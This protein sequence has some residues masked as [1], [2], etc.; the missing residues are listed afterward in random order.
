MVE[1]YNINRDKKICILYGNCQ[2]DGL[3]KFLIYSKFY[4]IYDTY[5]FPNWRMIENE[6]LFPVQLM[7]IADLIIYQ[8]LTEI[9]GCYST[10]INS[11]KSFFKLLKADCI[12]ISFP[13]IHN[14]ALFP[15]F[16]KH[17]CKNIFYG[18]DDSIDINDKLVNIL[19]K[20]KTNKL[21]FNFEKRW[22]S[23]IE[24]SRKREEMCDIKIIDFIIS[25][26]SKYKLFLTQDHPTSIV[27][28]EVA[29]QICVK[30]GLEYN[31]SLNLVMNDNIVDLKDS[32]YDRPQNQYP[33]SRYSIKF[34]G[35]EY[36]KCEDEDADEFYKRNLI[37]YYYSSKI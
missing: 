15:I 7:K 31:C 12:K 3:Q 23:N 18:G 2:C 29:R 33:I 34:Y 32:V 14:N 28:N 13:R 17:K 8:P 37:N 1:E 16:K 21:D 24:I 19:E 25:N 9:H 27:F 10:D 20:Y 22:I 5:Y 11:P 4:N 30:L 35:F 6:E 26:V 36:I